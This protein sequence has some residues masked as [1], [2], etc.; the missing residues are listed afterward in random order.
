ME[1]PEITQRFARVTTYLPG[2][3]P[4]AGRKTLV[5]EKIEDRLVEL[6]EI[7]S[8]RSTSGTGVAVIYGGAEGGPSGR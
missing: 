6:E 8:L 7:E 4:R 2:A 1:D 3:T 5:T